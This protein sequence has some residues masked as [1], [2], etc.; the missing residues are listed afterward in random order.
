[1]FEIN[2]RFLFPIS[3]PL[4]KFSIAL[5]REKSIK[6]IVGA[7]KFSTSLLIARWRWPQKNILAKLKTVFLNML[8]N[9]C[10]IHPFIIL[11]QTLTNF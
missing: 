11:S 3:S 6:S 9:I 10:Y 4:L 8:D 2:H 7:E 1:M 5:I